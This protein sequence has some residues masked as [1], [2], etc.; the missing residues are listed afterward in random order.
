MDK[1]LKELRPNLKESSRKNYVINIK[2]VYDLI[3]IKT[4]IEN[5]SWIKDNYKQIIKELDKIDNK[6]RQRNYL[7]SVIVYGG[8][9]DKIK[10]TDF[11][12]A[13]SDKRNEINEFFNTEDSKNTKNEKQEKNWV[14]VEEINSLI[15]KYETDLDKVFKK[16]PKKITA[17]E[18][19][20]LQ[21]YVLLF[22]NSKIPSRN[23]FS[24]LRKI[25]TTNYM[26]KSKKAKCDFNWVVT[27]PGGLDIY[28]YNHKT[29]K[30][31][32]DF[33][34]IKGMSDKF[35]DVLKMYISKVP[36]R[37]FI[38]HKN[39]KPLTNNGM[40]LILNKIF[41]KEFG[42]KVSSTMLRHIVLTTQLSKDLVKRKE[43]ANNLGHSLDTQERYIKN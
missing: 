23:A 1:I 40:T 41:M 6:H 9:R 27:K 28:L 25:T 30:D 43:L 15:E 5:I 10:D 26:R 34:K 37:E 35:V 13:L 19:E 33:I 22:I 8:D 14:S 38:F 16:S 21:E 36:N 39:G 2:K 32:D 11:F 3:D 31:C 29:K 20:K 24:T 17:K 12:K 4:P 42:K 18:L 7:N